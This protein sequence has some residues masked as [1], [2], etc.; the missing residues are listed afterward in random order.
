MDINDELYAPDV[1]YPMSPRSADHRRRD[2]FVTYNFA[3][4]DAI[5]DW[6]YDPLPDQV[7]LDVTP[8]GKVRTVIR[9]IG[10]GRWTGLLRLYPYDERAHPGSTATGGS[11]RC[12]PSTATTSTPTV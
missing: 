8:E 12:P 1:R 2:E 4:F 10:S 5:P 3:F 7:Y 11:S 9:Y 6:R